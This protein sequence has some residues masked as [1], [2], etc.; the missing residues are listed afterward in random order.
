[1]VTRQFKAS[2][3]LLPKNQTDRTC[4]GDNALIFFLFF[5]Y[6]NIVS[7]RLENRE[8]K[9]IL[10]IKLSIRIT[11]FEINVLWIAINI[12]ARELPN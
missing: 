11:V 9:F 10:Q 12:F 6:T 3:L 1:M 4:Y 7:A 8:F 2:L 5:F